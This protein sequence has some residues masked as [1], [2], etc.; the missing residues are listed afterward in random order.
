M[1]TEDQARQI[2]ADFINQTDPHWTNKPVMVVTGAEEAHLG[3]LFCWNSS[4]YLAT[5][6]IACALAGNGPVYVSRVTGDIEIL[7]T[8]PPLG[9]RIQEAEQRLKSKVELYGCAKV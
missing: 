1:V 2:A 9:K 6:D 8:V 7:E 3:W 5:K 4:D